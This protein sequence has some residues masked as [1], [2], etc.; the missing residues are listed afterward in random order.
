M[1]FNNPIFSQ[2]YTDTVDIYR[3]VCATG[4]NLNRQERKKINSAPIPCR[5][6]NAEK[7][8]PNM[9][10]HAAREQSSEKMA[11]DLAVDIQAGDELKIIRG[12]NLGFGNK[13]ER[14]FAGT[15]VDYYDPV[16]G[17]L[18]GLQHKEVGLF[19]DNII[20]R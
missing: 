14:Y 9:A 15:P 7:K 3:V 2:W 19:K 4:S 16:G 1:I 13:E 18:T 5:I 17:V 20:G 12:G 6:Y 8:G 11:C 10:G